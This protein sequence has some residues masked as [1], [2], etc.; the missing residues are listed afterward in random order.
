MAFIVRN[1]EIVPIPI[2]LGKRVKIGSAYNVP[3]ENHV[4]N[5]QLWIQDIYTFNNIPWYAIRNRYEKYLVAVLLYLAIVVMLSMI[6][7]YYLGAPG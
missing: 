1:Q 4:A 7:R 6:G 5:D 3:L 2:P